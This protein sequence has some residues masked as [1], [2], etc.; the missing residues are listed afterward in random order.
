MPYL[1]VKH[2]IFRVDLIVSPLVEFVHNAEA[3][4]TLRDNILKTFLQHVVTTETFA[5]ESRL[6]T[7]E[8]IQRS[9]TNLPIPSIVVLGGF[10]QHWRNALLQPWSRSWRERSCERRY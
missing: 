4:L 10:G 5:L 9:R 2:S 7:A 3:D 6:H 1:N 8:I